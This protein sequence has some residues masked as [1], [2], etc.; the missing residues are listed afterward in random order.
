MSLGDKEA[1]V[2]FQMQLMR[3]DEGLTVIVAAGN[4]FWDACDFAPAGVPAAITVGPTGNGGVFEEL[5]EDTRSVSSNF[6]ACVDIYA[7]G[8]LIFPAAHA[9]PRGRRG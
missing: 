3:F 7:P 4:S 8:H 2:L 6:G 9:D 5:A 1:T